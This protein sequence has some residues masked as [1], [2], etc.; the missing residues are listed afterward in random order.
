MRIRRNSQPYRLLK[1]L[2]IGTGVL[3]LSLI[4]PVSGAMLVK[5]FIRYYFRN[6]KF[7]KYRFLNDLK[8]L[9]SRELVSYKEEGRGVVKI[10]LTKNGR[11]KILRYQIDEIKIK[12]PARW[13]GQWRLIMFDIPHYKRIARD[14]FRTKLKNLEFY[15]I[16]KSVF[17]TPYPCENEIDFIASILM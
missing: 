12:K 10:T 13:D 8:N 2:A 7:Q 11:E 14:A 4:A 1:Y 6:K 9:Q 15:P 5:N 3:T 17:I 16:Q